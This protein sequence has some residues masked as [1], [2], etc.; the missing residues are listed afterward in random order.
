[1]DPAR[2]TFVVDAGTSPALPV[3]EGTLALDFRDPRPDAVWDDPL[4]VL[5]PQIKRG[6][7]RWVYAA[8]APAAPRPFLEDERSRKW[9]DRRAQCLLLPAAVRQALAPLVAARVKGASDE[10]DKVEA[11]ADWIRAECAYSLTD[12]AGGDQPVVE[13]LTRV[14]RGHCD[15]F[16]AALA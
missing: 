11:L 9:R 15:H 10:R 14:R 5:R 2:T 4:R 3:P 16:A 6:V 12:G 13:F 7:Q 8:T 1:P